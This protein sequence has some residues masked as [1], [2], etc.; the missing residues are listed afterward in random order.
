M[1]ISLMIALACQREPPPLERANPIAPV[2]APPLGIDSRLSD[3]PDPPTSARVRLGR[4]LFYDK[5]LS[6]DGTIACATCHRPEHAYSEPTAVSTGI[7]GQK[8][9]RKAPSF[10]NQAWTLF[11]HFFWDGRAA[12]L[13]EQAL[14]PVANPIEMGNTHE[15]MVAIITRTSEYAPYFRE[16]FG[17][18]AITKERVANAIADYERTRMSGNSAWDRWRKNR[19]ET[20]V[21]AD[22]KKGHEL[23]FGKAACNQ[24]HLGQNFTDSLFHNIGVGWNPKTNRF[25]DDGR[26]LVTNID[27]DRGAFKTP[28][29]RDVTIHAPYM[30]DGSI[31]TLREVVELYNRGGL[32]N[33]FLDPKL[34]PLNL[35]RDEIDALVKFMEALTGEGPRE[36][37]PAAFPGIR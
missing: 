23:F 35:A 6:A 26:Y 27:S 22:V 8:G 25:A 7:R 17:T 21:L 14:G 11:P 34:Q 28:T 12:S 37:P 5:R 1:A 19:D 24:C 29:L 33:P 36:T 13:E 3:L 2:P 30:H 20:A 16:A 4:W 15:A 18:P 31:K 32:K 10:I 9:G